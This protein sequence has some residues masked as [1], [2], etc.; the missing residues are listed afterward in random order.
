MLKF[1]F[2]G[3]DKGLLGAQRREKSFIYGKGVRAIQEGLMEEIA[4][5]PGLEEWVVFGFMDV[6]GSTWSSV[7]LT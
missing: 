1:Y 7:R 4:F 6:E 3:E 5:E 2:G